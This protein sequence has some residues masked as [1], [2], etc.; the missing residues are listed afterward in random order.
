M[1]S[2]SLQPYLAIAVSVLVMQD[3]L[4]V[5]KLKRFLVSMPSTKQIEQAL[6]LAVVQLAEQ[7]VFAFEWV[8]SHQAM[9]LPELDLKAFVKKLVTDRLRH[10]EAL[11]SPDRGWTLGED[12]ELSALPLPF[13]LDARLSATFEQHFSEGER[14]LLMSV[15]S[16]EPAT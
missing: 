3:A 11:Q 9:L 8:L 10:S 15:L 14:V 1:D 4:A 5:Q 12:F 2:E 13:L 16:S 7:D 6:G